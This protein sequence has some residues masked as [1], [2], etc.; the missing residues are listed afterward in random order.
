MFDKALN[1]KKIFTEKAEPIWTMCTV[2]KH[3]EKL[4]RKV[5]ESKILKIANLMHLFAKN[6]FNI[7]GNL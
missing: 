6:K 4:D 3:Q 5:K 1:H 7:R 2:G